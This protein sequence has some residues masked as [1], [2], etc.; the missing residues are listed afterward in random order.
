[1]DCKR[2]P[3][4]V[5]PETECMCFA[6]SD[7]SDPA[8]DQFCGYV[9]RDGETIHPCLQNCCNG[10]LG[11]PGQCRGVDP[12]RPDGTRNIE[13]KPT[14]LSIL[15]PEKRLT[16]F[17]NLFKILILLVVVSTLSLFLRN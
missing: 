14:G 4:C 7:S 5:H 13:G 3:Q 16:M 15:H 6:D 9:G 10:G 2:L 1:M 12:K 17:E 8:S 11:C